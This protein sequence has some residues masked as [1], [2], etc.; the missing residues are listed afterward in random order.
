MKTEYTRLLP[1]PHAYKFKTSTSKARKERRRDHFVEQAIF[2]QLISNR[3]Y[4]F[5]DS[6]ISISSTS[7]SLSYFLREVRKVKYPMVA[8]LASN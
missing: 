6:V 1:L 4:S 3:I 5:H 8:Y 7:S 2:G